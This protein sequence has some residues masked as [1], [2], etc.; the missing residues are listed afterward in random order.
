MG[1]N[2]TIRKAIRS[3]LDSNAMLEKLLPHIKGN[4]GFVF[5]KEDLSVVRDLIM[6]NRVTAIITICCWTDTMSVRTKFQLCMVGHNTKVIRHQQ[7]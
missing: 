5:T 6:A 2:T 4:V 7:T 3:H 1:K